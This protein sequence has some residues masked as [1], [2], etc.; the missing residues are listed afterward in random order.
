MNR[1][2]VLSPSQKEIGLLGPAS[3]KKIETIVKYEA[4]S[5]REW[6]QNNEKADAEAQIS[7]TSVAPNSRLMDKA[8]A[9][10]NREE[11]RQL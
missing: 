10:E 8:R 7:L 4:R 1:Y 9:E 2:S 5:P 11:N 6:S 3:Q